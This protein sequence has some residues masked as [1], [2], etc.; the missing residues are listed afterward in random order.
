MTIDVANTTAHKLL[1]TAERLFAEEGLDAL[2]TRR[3]SSEA[4][5]RNNS[6]LQYHFGSKDALL[7]A[8]LEYRQG[9]INRRRMVLLE[10]LQAQ[11]RAAQLP[12]LVEAMVLPYLELLTG[13]VED[14]YYLSLVSQLHSQQRQA[15]LFDTGHERGRSLRLLSEWLTLALAPL[16]EATCHQRLELASL[17]LVH[18]AALWAHQRRQA[19]QPWSQ[20]QVVARTGQLVDFLAGGLQAVGREPDDTNSGSN[21]Q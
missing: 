3:I 10:T 20:R 12:A 11:G 2:S 15:L 9:P 18:T 7:E 14:S 13:A 8:L 21:E 19:Q 6:A 16:P 5:Q 1:L 4:G 17:T